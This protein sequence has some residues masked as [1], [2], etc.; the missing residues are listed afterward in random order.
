MAER[1][2]PPFL[3]YQ[4]AICRAGRGGGKEGGPRRSLP[5]APGIPA[6]AALRSAGS[7]RPRGSAAFPSRSRAE[8]AAD[9]HG[10]TRV[11][12]SDV[13]GAGPPYVTPFIFPPVR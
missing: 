8:P 13:P 7:P 5:P 12:A 2:H 1:A 3:N 6:P 10:G 11:C 4:P 9:A